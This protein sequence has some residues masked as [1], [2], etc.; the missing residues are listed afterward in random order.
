MFKRRLQ[1]LRS[2]FTT[3]FAFAL[4][5]AV[6]VFGL[7]GQ[8]ANATPI[9]VTNSGFEAIPLSDGQFTQVPGFG[10]VL[11]TCVASTAPVPAWTP[12][13]NATNVA[14]L[15]PTVG[16]FPTIPGGE[17]IAV[18]NGGAA[19]SQT[20][21][22]ILTANTLYTLEVFV[23]NRLDAPFPGYIVELFAGAERIIVE[24][25]LTPGSGEFALSSSTFTALAGDSSLGETLEIRLTSLGL[26]T[27]FDNVSLTAATLSVSEPGALAIFALGLAGTYVSTRRRK[28]TQ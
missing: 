21:P 1:N 23:G 16:M 11:P 3:S 22:A 4:L 19:L 17:N 13:G 25:S 18:I 28:A 26:Q 8:T 15:N 12:I 9:A 6:A 27:A 14:T 24:E 10:C 20:L 2:V 5:V 7:F